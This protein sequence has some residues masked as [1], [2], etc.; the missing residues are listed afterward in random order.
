MQR[1]HISKLFYGIALNV[2]LCASP[3]FAFWPTFDIAEVANTVESWVSQV[4]TRLSTIQ[5]TISVSNIQQAIGDKLG[6]LGKLKNLEAKANKA[7]QKLDKAKKRAEKVMKLKKQYEQEAKKV[8]GQV[9]NTYNQ[10]MGVVNEAQNTVQTAINE[11]NNVKNQVEG[12]VNQA[13]NTV[14]NAKNQV[15][16]AINQVNNVKNQI[17]NKVGDVKNQVEGVVNQV[18]GT[19]NGVQNTAQNI[20]NSATNLYGGLQNGFAQSG[21]NAAVSAG[22][23]PSTFVHSADGEVGFDYNPAEDAFVSENESNM[24]T[25]VVTYTSATGLN[26]RQAPMTSFEGVGLWEGDDSVELTNSPEQTLPA[27][28]ENDLANE[29]LEGQIT[30]R[31]Q[32]GVV[33]AKVAPVE[34]KADVAPAG[35]ASGLEKLSVESAEISADKAD[36][37]T[38]AVRAPALEKPILRKAFEKVSYYDVFTHGYAAEAK[39]ATGTD[40]DANYYFP[41]T[42]AMWTGINFD[43]KLDEAK[44]NTAV[45]TICADLN[46]ADDQKKTEFVT[47]YQKLLAEASAHAEA[48]SAASVKESEST[49]TSDDLENMLGKTDSMLTQM[50]ATGEILASEIEENKREL[51]MLADSIQTE[52][53]RE[54]FAYCSNYTPEEEK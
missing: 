41:D 52:V 35:Q 39:F 18:E 38:D 44:M 29:K 32:E 27:V 26:D 1:K 36:T 54:L 21:G 49:A 2:L 51:V 28:S 34:A 16:G 37:E 10:A 24:A 20:G 47:Q 6:G 31:V 19:V 30:E 42:F 46:T 12:A 8:L 14:N 40:D 9:Q 43:E 7:K 17:E 25:G 3:A 22:S 50:S 53:F 5:E 48:Y 45:S 11:V 13:V 23:N 4:E 33:Q 15:E